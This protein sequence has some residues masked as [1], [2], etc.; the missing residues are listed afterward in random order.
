MSPILY[1]SARE[2]QRFYRRLRQSS[3][4]H[5]RFEARATANY[6][7]LPEEG[8]E[9]TGTPLA[10]LE[11]ESYL[12]FAEEAMI[13]AGLPDESA[14][15]ILGRVEKIRAH[16]R[17]PH[18]YVA[19]I[20][21]LSSG[22]TTFI[23]AVLRDNLLN[24]SAPG[25]TGSETRVCYNP[26][27]YAEAEFKDGT[28]LV[29]RGT[30][31]S[32]AELMARIFSP[33]GEELEDRH[34]FQGDEIGRQHLREFLAQVTTGGEDE[35]EGLTRLTLFHPSPTLKRGLVLIDTPGSSTSKSGH[36]RI[37]RAV[38]EEIADAAVVVIPATSRISQPFLDFL[39][40][41]AVPAPHCCLFVA[42]RMDQI[43]RQEYQGTV[44]AIGRRLAV[45]LPSEAPEVHPC[46]PRTVLDSLAGVKLSLDNAAWKDRF[47]DFES[48]AWPLLHKRR[49]FI[50]ADS[51][52]RKIGA[53]LEA[54]DES[55]QKQKAVHQKRRGEIE[56]QTVSDLPDFCRE[57]QEECREIVEQAVGE[58]QKAVQVILRDHAQHVKQRTRTA[59]RRASDIEEL[60]TVVGKKI[61]EFLYEAG[62][63][64]QQDINE[65]LG[66]L[67]QYG[68]TAAG[69]FQEHFSDEFC[70]FEKIREFGQPDPIQCQT[71]HLRLDV[72][73]PPP[74][75][76]AFVAQL[77]GRSRIEKLKDNLS[78]GLERRKDE[79]W[80]QVE[81]DLDAYYRK[82]E[83]PL[84]DWVSREG[85][86]IS[87]ALNEYAKRHVTRYGPLLDEVRSEMSQRQEHISHLSETIDTSRRD[88]E[89][90]RDSLV[91]YRLKLASE[92]IETKDG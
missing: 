88:I 64:L 22:K 87:Q 24:T 14:D 45:N 57:H 63:T 29:R 55:L 5:G 62:K 86:F 21:E 26:D 12:N 9:E 69:R 91:R 25:T 70:R 7:P 90:M 33:Y 19:V 37:T 28:R 92:M 54:L 51:L 30:Y 8:L 73:K 40:G 35:P 27:L 15:D 34:S 50:R 13:R 77:D 17:D 66:E 47:D 65:R 10:S 74:S 36:A 59:I 80:K 43:Q 52:A 2:V 41:S 42:T 61:H 39:K 1:Q 4:I 78:Q 85:R 53:M 3:I 6:Y 75:T 16:R 46:S 31:F 71:K 79:A 68:R 67:A 60:K 20:G 82:L 72:G 81:P 83:G 32:S 11:V 89:R 44:E 18:L 76:K 56:R 48:K 84:E 38:L 58:A 23:N 49:T